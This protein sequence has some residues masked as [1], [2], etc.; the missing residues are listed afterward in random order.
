MIDSGSALEIAGAGRHRVNIQ[1]AGREKA[2]SPCMW[3]LILPTR[4][5]P[6][7]GFVEVCKG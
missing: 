6:D 3:F 7:E 4:G 5:R 2:H 1:R